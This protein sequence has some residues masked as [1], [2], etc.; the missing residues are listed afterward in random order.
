MECPVCGAE[1]QDVT[2]ISTERRG[3]K[4]PSCGEYEISG[5]I[6]DSGMLGR[7][8][9]EARKRALENAKRSAPAGKRPMITSDNL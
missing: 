7:L 1:A 8:D 9:E 2:E 6:Y 3:I 4:C 5:T